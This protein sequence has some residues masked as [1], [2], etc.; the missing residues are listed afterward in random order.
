[1]SDFN[2]K[3]VNRLKQKHLCCPRKVLGLADLG[4]RIANSPMLQYRF[5]CKIKLKVVLINFQNY[6]LLKIIYMKL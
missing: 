6:F 1:M 5:P 3:Q 4:G 2:F